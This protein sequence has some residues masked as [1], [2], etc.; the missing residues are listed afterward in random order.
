MGHWSALGIL[1]VANFGYQAMT[2]HEWAV[3]VERSWFQ[4]I[5]IFVCWWIVRGPEWLR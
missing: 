1:T 2:H 3:A 4:A 5:A